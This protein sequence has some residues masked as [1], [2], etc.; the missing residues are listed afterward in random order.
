MICQRV[1]AKIKVER[2]Q[3]NLTGNNLCDFY[4]PYPD[5]Y[6]NMYDADEPIIRH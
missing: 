6:R 1:I 4:N 2:L 5:K 3:F